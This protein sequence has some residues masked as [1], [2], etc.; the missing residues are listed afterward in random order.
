MNSGL[1]MWTST[2]SQ[3]QGV[4]ILLELSLVFSAWSTPYASTGGVC[5]LCL[6]LAMVLLGTVISLSKGMFR[7]R[8]GIPS[9]LS[10]VILRCLDWCLLVKWIERSRGL[11][12]GLSYRCF[13]PAVSFSVFFKILY[14]CNSTQMLFLYIQ[15]P[16]VEYWCSP[17]LLIGIEFGLPNICGN[18]VEMWSTT[19]LHII[20]KDFSC[21]YLLLNSQICGLKLE[22]KYRFIH[23]VLVFQSYPQPNVVLV[24]QSWR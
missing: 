2:Q 8:L 12:R 14:I 16:T 10:C 1:S 22:I 5:F 11:V 19:H 3:Q 13:D 15:T 20:F 17:L 9:G 24:F 4:G 23:L 6:Y 7:P 18:D 21:F